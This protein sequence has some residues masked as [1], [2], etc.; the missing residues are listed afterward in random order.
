MK[1]DNYP[2]VV[3]WSNADDCWIADTPDLESCTAHGD[4][5]EAAVRE[6]LVARD[7][8]LASAREHQ[9]PL[10]DPTASPYL[11]WFAR[12]AGD[13]SPYVVGAAGDAAGEG[14]AT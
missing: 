1:Q 3:F 5:P 14:V 11:P 10:P 4:T 8:C 13:Q 9:L 7:L 6:A 2:I 12:D